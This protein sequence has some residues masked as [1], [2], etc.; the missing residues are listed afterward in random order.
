M[1]KVLTK[2][3]SLRAKCAKQCLLLLKYWLDCL[4]WDEQLLFSNSHKEW[5]ACSLSF[6]LVSSIFQ[7]SRKLAHKIHLHRLRLHSWE[8]RAS[9]HS[10]DRNKRSKL[11]QQHLNLIWQRTRKTKFHCPSSFTFLLTR[12]I[13]V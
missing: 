6:W 2:H 5:I 13:R 3:L 7:M 11:F 10:T 8:E 4:T 9:L 12:K 1:K